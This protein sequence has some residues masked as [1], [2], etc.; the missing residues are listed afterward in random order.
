[1]Y[2][3]GLLPISIFSSIFKFL[4]LFLTLYDHSLLGFN[5]L[6]NLTMLIF[7]TFFV[8]E[9]IF[10]SSSRLTLNLCEYVLYPEISFLDSCGCS[11]SPIWV[12]VLVSV[13]NL[14][15]VIN[16]SANLI[17][18]FSIGELFKKVVHRS[19][20]MMP[21]FSVRESVGSLRYRMS[22]TSVTTSV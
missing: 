6:P 16:S 21:Q 12:S 13:S 15:L 2:S 18:Y 7:L 11:Q 5:I 19:N 10:L 4:R 22:N 20:S 9:W 8:W 3:A 17:I 1:M 14:F